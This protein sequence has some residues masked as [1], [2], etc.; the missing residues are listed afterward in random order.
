MPTFESP[1]QLLDWVEANADTLR[2]DAS[3]QERGSRWR[4][5][6]RMED[7]GGLRRRISIALPD[8]VTAMRVKARLDRWRER[9]ADLKDAEEDIPRADRE[10]RDATRD[11]RRRFL[12]VCAGG[13][14]HR[15]RMARL[16]D[17]V[18]HLGPDYLADFMHRKPWTIR[19]QPPGR[20]RTITNFMTT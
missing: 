2:C 18:A 16:F 7:D 10:R 14:K 15:K 6:A 5:R 19:P 1:D 9:D 20:P 8:T 11:L 13:G 4:L 3:V 17:G 12:N